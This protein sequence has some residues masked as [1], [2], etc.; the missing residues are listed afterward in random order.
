MQAL[1]LLHDAI[2]RRGTN[3][4]CTDNADIARV[5]LKIGVRHDMFRIVTNGRVSLLSY[6]DLSRLS[7]VD[8]CSVSSACVLK[9]IGSFKH[10]GKS[11]R[12]HNDSAEKK[13]SRA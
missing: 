5:L 8:S 11:A 9:N 3:R 7:V 2:S 10:I 6:S 4:P 13:L 1:T 12:S